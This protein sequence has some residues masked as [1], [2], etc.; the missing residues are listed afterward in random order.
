MLSLI[1]WKND[2]FTALVE[3]LKQGNVNHTLFAGYLSGR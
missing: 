2:T 3:A 1:E